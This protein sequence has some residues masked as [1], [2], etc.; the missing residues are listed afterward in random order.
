MKLARPLAAHTGLPKLTEELS[1]S[2]E[3]WMLELP[4]E[5]LQQAAAPRHRG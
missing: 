1:R 5:A 3:Q 4:G 2:P